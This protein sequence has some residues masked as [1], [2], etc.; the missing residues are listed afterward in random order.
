LRTFNTDDIAFDAGTEGN[1]AWFSLAEKE[2][3]HDYR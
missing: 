2:T 3:L 1:I